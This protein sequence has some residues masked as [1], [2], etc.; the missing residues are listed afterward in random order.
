MK[1]Q[2]LITALIALSGM[3]WIFL[4]HAPYFKPVTGW[5]ELNGQ[6]YR[7]ETWH[8][9]TPLVTDKVRL[10]LRD[11]GGSLRAASPAGY[12][13]KTDCTNIAQCIIIFYTNED[14]PEFYPLQSWIAEPPSADLSKKID[15]SNFYAA[16]AGFRADTGMNNLIMGNI[17]FA[18]IITEILWYLGLLM[19]GLLLVTGMRAQPARRGVYKFVL[20][21]LPLVTGMVY[22]SFAPI[23]TYQLILMVLLGIG[24]AFTPIW[25]IC[26]LYHS[27]LMRNPQKRLKP[28]A[29]IYALLAVLFISFPFA[30]QAMQNALSDHTPLRAEDMKMDVTPELK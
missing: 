28:R 18:N 30:Q 5:Q 16:P 6:R 25:A 15:D 26:A 17:C 27:L 22:V 3:A 20:V 11:E 9:N 21:G 23:V 12:L 7:A 14:N 29:I 10:V 1:K 24:L 2:H 19:T 8:S 4:L 13:K